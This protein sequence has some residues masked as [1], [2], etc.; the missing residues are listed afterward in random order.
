KEFDRKYV[1]IEVALLADKQSVQSWEKSKLP[2][3]RQEEAKVAAAA[4][5]AQ[6]RDTKKKR[7]RGPRAPN[8]LSCKKRKIQHIEEEEQTTKRKRTRSRRQRGDRHED[9][10]GGAVDDETNSTH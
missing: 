1:T 2:L 8:P 7:S 5:E 9:E 4:D 6:Q 10:E 3:L